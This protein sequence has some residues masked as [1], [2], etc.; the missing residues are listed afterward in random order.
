[1]RIGYG[2]LVAGEL[3]HVSAS[4]G[5]RLKDPA[6]HSVMGRPLRRVDIPRKLTGGEAYVQDMRLPGMVHARTLRPPGY[7]AALKSLD[8]AAALRLPGILKVVR[9]G[10]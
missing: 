7:D 10:R 5:A 2:E 3:L 1:R 8:T 9:D 4:P 6:T